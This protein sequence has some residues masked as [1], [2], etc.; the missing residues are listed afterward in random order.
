MQEVVYV[1]VLL[2]VNLFVNYFLLRAAS[3]LARERVRRRRL[4]L[5]AV[6]G[7][8]YSLIIFLPALHPLFLLVLQAFM[9]LTIVWAAF[10]RRKPRAFLRLLGCFLAETFL[11]GG[12]NYAVYTFI[13]PGGMIYGNSAVYYN[14]SVP[15]LIAVTAACY[16]ISCLVSRLLR[17]NAPDHLTGELFLRMNGK[18]V[19]VPALVDSGNGLSDPFSDEPVSVVCLEA[20]K[21]LFSPDTCRFLTEGG[22]PPDDLQAEKIRIIP[23][24]SVGGSGSLY[25]FR[26][27]E[28]E[29]ILL[30]G[31][32]DVHESLI[33]VVER[34]FDNGR[35]WALVHPRMAEREGGKKRGEA[36][37]S[38]KL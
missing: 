3:L 1:D 34:P 29:L 5:G 31:K 13:R 2:F 30:T 33:A 36:P 8:I 14:I 22:I 26:A 10:G 28:A 20:V 18:S 19:R 37:L 24:S 17:K 23:Y 21:P 12:V 9:A 25:A 27:D 6:L 38:F 35:Y 16:G 7:S 11:F 15:M 32:S 4:V